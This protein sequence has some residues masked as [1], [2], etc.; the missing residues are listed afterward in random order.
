MVRKGLFII[1][2]S[3]GAVNLVVL[4][5][6]PPSELTWIEAEMNAVG[7]K[8]EVV[9]STTSAAVASQRHQSSAP[10]DSFAV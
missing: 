6:L 9:E 8:V 10:S 7:R 4:T 1:V 2:F 5:P 3:I